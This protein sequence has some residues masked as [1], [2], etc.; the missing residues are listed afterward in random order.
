VLA[1]SWA[2]T[3]SCSLL[4]LCFIQS[5]GGWLDEPWNR[6]SPFVSLVYCG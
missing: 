6:I 5:S 3:G 4:L 1:A 2:G